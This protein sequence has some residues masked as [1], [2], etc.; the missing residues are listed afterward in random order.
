MKLNSLFRRRPKSHVNDEGIDGFDWDENQPKWPAVR[1]LNTTL[2]VISVIVWIVL[3]FRLFVFSPGGFDEMILL[4]EKAAEIYPK[5]ESQVLRIHSNTDEDGKS[6]LVVRYPVY[7]EEAQNFQLT[8][9]VNRRVLKPGKE[10]TDYTFILRESGGEETKFYP[11]SYSDFQK[12]WNYTF[13]RLCFD[14]VNLDE[15]K[16]Y[17]LLVYSGQEEGKDGVFEAKDAD[18]TFTVYNSDTYC[19]TITPDEDIYTYI[20]E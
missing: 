5:E 14:G 8:A 9:Q 19:N 12:K 2:G 3:L 11:V 16:V 6:G 20:I 1:I 13:Y 4:D 10:G 17:T 18:F 7:L 15:M